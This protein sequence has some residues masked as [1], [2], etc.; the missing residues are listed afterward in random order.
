MKYL[1]FV[2]LMAVTSAL[3]AQQV[4][5]NLSAS[6]VSPAVFQPSNASKLYTDG[7]LPGQRMRNTGRTLTILGTGL[8]VGGI[9][10]LSNADETYY[11]TTYSSNGSYEEGD[12]QAAVGVLMMTGGAGMMIPGIIFWSKGA[13]KYKVSLQEQSPNASLHVRGNGLAIRYRF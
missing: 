1:V 11:N 9:V 3:H 10:V 4:T 5:G 2:L 7:L 13:R 12:P 6:L 8:F